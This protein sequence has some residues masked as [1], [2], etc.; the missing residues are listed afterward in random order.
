[1]PRCYANPHPIFQPAMRL[2]ASITQSNPAVVTTTFANQ[3][4]TGEIVRLDIPTACGMQ[5]AN[6]L[7]GTIIVTADDTF[8]IDIDTTFFDAFAIPISPGPHDNI[9]AQVVPIGEVNEEL[10][11]ATQNVLPSGQRK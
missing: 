8:T 5:Q 10:R 7:V 9:C 4:L 2:I 6:G 3:Y 1:M 11:L